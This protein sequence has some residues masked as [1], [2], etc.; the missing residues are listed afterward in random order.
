MTLPVPACQT[1]GDG[2]LTLVLLHGIGGNRHVWP[3]Q[4]ET[5]A[6][7]G[8]RV[9]AWD[10][11]GYGESALPAEP[12]MASL[13]DSLRALLDA[14]G[15][16]RF[17]LVGH[18]MGGMVAQELMARGAPFTRDI[19]AL[20]LCGTSP[21]FGKPDGDFQREFVRQRT[22]PLD[23]GKTLRE[24][25]EAIVPGML[26]EPDAAVR[27]SAH[28][29]AVDAMGAL[30][31]DAYRAALQAL[32][33]FEQRAALAR[34]AVPVLLIAGEHDTNAPPKVMARMAE[35]IPQARYVCLP[36]AGH[37]M[38]LTHPAAFNAEVRAFL[39]T[40]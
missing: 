9:V 5:F 28:A 40:L 17:V 1:A 38:N 26:G 18:S 10:M 4:F 36:G 35:S 25:A 32:V 37:L 11:P 2:P 14:L 6:T 20:V 24:M 16:S 31:P 30:T 19:A 21:A 12:T 15:P 29:V 3:A 33:G 8:H 23:A 27:A 34:I 22:A 13:A 7:A 39:A